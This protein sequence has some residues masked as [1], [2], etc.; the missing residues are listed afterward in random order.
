MQYK[1][2]VPLFP[3]SWPLSPTI[4]V[5]PSRKVRCHTFDAEIEQSFALEVCQ[6]NLSLYLMTAQKMGV[7]LGHLVK[8]RLQGDT[9][10]LL[11]VIEIDYYCGDPPDMWIAKLTRCEPTP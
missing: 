3:F 10:I 9:D 8:V 6:D 1:S 2:W 11:K 4:R 7:Q 5:N